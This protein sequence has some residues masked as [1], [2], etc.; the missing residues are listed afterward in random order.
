MAE[1]LLLPVP[2]LTPLRIRYTHQLRPCDMAKSPLLLLSPL[3][4]HQIRYMP[5]L[6]LCDMAKWSSQAC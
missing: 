3:L 2:L 1:A 6:R 5:Q 4:S